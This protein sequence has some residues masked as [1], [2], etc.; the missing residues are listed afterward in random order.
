MVRLLERHITPCQNGAMESS[1][2][3]NL[4]TLVHILININM[5]TTLLDRF[6]HG[7]LTR[8]T[9]RNFESTAAQRQRDVH[10]IIR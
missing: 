6:N 8:L 10:C 1:P 9:D 5:N 3:L 7:M 2:R 4:Y